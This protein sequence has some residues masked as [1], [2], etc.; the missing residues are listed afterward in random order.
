MARALEVGFDPFFSMN[1]PSPLSL[2]PQ[3]PASAAKS[4]AGAGFEGTGLYGN[5]RPLAATLIEALRAPFVPGL[6]ARKVGSGLA[7][8]QI[9]FT[10]FQAL[11]LVSLI[12]AFVGATIMLQ[13]KIMASAIPGELIGQILV[14][15]ILREL[16]P[17][18]TATII[19][20]RS[21]TAIATE[22]GNMRVNQEVLALSS[23]GID[24]C[25]FIVWPRFI[26]SVVSVLVLTVY[27]GMIAILSG[28]VMGLMLGSSTFGDLQVGFA[29]A[30][31][32]ADIVL[33]VVKCTGLGTLVG[34]LCCHFGLSVEGSPTEVPEKASKAVIMSLLA[35]VAYNT[36]V[37]AAFYWIFGSHIT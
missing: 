4:G 10:G 9:F 30:L 2:F 26:G 21:G 23:M 20:G 19:A 32:R 35:C 29:S 27:F 3:R 5:K 24:P 18:T 17:L 37:T 15:T 16:A 22:L 33:Y 7:F 11:P 8:R 31:N 1:D 6:E 14:A 13:M 12:A 25:R 34:W 36:A 28:C